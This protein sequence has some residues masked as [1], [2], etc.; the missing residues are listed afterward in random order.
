LTGGR[1]VLWS[2]GNSQGKVRIRE[3]GGSPSHGLKAV[4]IQLKK[5][6]AEAEANFG[7]RLESRGNSMART[8]RDAVLFNLILLGLEL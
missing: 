4:A 6:K 2:I 3:R 1:L 8:K 7:S 5:E